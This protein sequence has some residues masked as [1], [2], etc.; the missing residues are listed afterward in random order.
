MGCPRSSL[1]RWCPSDV[2]KVKE[3]VTEG[4]STGGEEL[5]TEE[6]NMTNGSKFN[7]VL[8]QNQ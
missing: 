2:D 7:I 3:W 4:K 6:A 5:K 8:E 1:Q